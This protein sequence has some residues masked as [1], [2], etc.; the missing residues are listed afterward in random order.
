MQ[1]PINEFKK[2]QSDIFWKKTPAGDEINYFTFHTYNKF[3][4]FLIQI[5]KKKK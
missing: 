3:W 2:F 4:A 1:H 5:Y